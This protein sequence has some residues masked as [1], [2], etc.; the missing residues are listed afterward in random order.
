M[1]NHVQLIDRLKK[2]EIYYIQNGTQTLQFKVF[3][4]NVI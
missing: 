4:V 2:F 1:C 3:N